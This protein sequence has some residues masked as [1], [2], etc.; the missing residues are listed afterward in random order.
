M[1]T[2]QGEFQ[3]SSSFFLNISF[4]PQFN[5]DAEKGTRFPKFEVNLALGI[6]C[7]SYSYPAGEQKQNAER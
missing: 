6:G 4:D 1:E 2:I 7:A 5:A 3:N